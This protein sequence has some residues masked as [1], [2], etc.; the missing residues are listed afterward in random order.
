MKNPYKHPADRELYRLVYEN[1]LRIYSQVP[2]DR[3]A[4]ST[5]I[6]NA[7]Y[8]VKLSGSDEYR[9]DRITYRAMHDAQME[10]KTR[11]GHTVSEQWLYLA[12]LEGE[13]PIYWRGEGEHAA[14]PEIDMDRAILVIQDFTD[15]LEK[16]IL[17]LYLY[18]DPSNFDEAAAREHAKR[19]YA[20][21]KLT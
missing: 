10:I 9:I 18:Y 13:A 16:T 20:A 19:L 14:G 1:T 3:M 2:Y 5:E 17:T 4:W 21:G 15:V 12:S 11:E 7:R 6:G 8:Q